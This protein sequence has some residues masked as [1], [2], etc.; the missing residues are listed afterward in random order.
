[1]PRSVDTDVQVLPN[2]KSIHKRVD[3]TAGDISA[4]LPDNSVNWLRQSDGALVAE[5]TGLYGNDGSDGDTSDIR[6]R[7]QSPPDVLPANQAFAQLDIQA[8]RKPS[9]GFNEADIT[10]TLDTPGTAQV[11]RTFVTH[12]D[13]SDFPIFDHIQRFTAVGPVP[14]SWSV[15]ITSPT[16]I[17]AVS[18][19][20]FDSVIGKHAGLPIFFN[21][22]Q[23]DGFDF[24][25][26]TAN[27]H[28]AYP[29]RFFIVT[30][31]TP[32]NKT[33]SV[34]ASGSSVTTDV[35][36]QFYALVLN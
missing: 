4:A 7:A 22:V 11:V 1:M 2:G 35:N 14:V 8:Q 26:N 34:N 29:T 15:A 12:L 17:F 28:M 6:L 10:A 23:R 16:A 24:F 19:S 31:L 13:Q 3:I 33:L 18:G 27:V 21:G 5:I 30:G 32:G 9:S 20:A 25:F 36:D